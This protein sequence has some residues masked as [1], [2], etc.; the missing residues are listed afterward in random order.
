MKWIWSISLLGVVLLGRN[1]YKITRAN[2][3]SPRTPASVTVRPNGTAF[4]EL[5]RLLDEQ[6]RLKRTHPVK[7][8]VGPRSVDFRSNNFVYDV[9]EVFQ[10]TPADQDAALVAWIQTRMDALPPVFLLELSR[11]LMKTSP[12]EAL[13]WYGVAILRLGYD[14]DRCTDRLGETVQWILMA[15]NELPAYAHQHREAYVAAIREAVRWDQ[16]RSVQSSPAWLCTMGMS[17]FGPPAG[18]GEFA[19]VE[20]DSLMKPPATWPAIRQ[21]GQRRFM[22]RADR[23]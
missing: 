4:T 15:Y 10:A 23:M 3:P 9:M 2:H 11:R 16:A 6:A 19:G 21:D 13:K 5:E 20:V 1:F 8:Q 7:R 22:E 18:N 14:L 17:A 12:P